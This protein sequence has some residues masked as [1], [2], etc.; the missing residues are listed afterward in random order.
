MMFGIILLH[1]K[2]EIPVSEGIGNKTVCK[3]H[4]F[5][6]ASFKIV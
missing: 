4:T 6:T 5:T 3:R 1:K 2:T